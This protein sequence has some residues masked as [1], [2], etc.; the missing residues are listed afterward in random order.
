MVLLFRNKAYLEFLDAGRKSWML[1]SG[2][3]ALDA[4]FWMLDSGRW[5]L[6]AGSYTWDTKVWAL[7]AVVDWFRTKS[8]PSF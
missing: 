2:R 8:E 5:T 1:D 3:W 4:G 6:D 7:D